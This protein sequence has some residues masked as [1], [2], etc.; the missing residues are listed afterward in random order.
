MC[1]GGSPKPPDPVAPPS[2]APTPT[3]VTNINPVATQTDRAATLKKLQYGLA[4][5]IK[6][7]PGGLT[8]TGANLTAPI[9]AGT[10]TK[11]GA[12]A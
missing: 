8:G 3:P 1:F 7:G 2:P 11:L 5:T 9:A 4:S 6:T 10:T 12:A